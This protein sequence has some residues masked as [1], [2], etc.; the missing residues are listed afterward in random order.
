MDR[1][2]TR[3][4]TADD[5]VAL[6]RRIKDLRLGRGLTIKELAK[7][8]ELSAGAI[9]QIERGI[10]STSIRSIR[11]ICK[12]LQVPLGILFGAENRDGENEYLCR[13]HQR[14]TLDFGHGTIKQKLTAKGVSNLELLAVNIEP[15]GSSGPDTYSHDGEEMGLVL[16]GVLD[17]YIAEQRYHL[18]EGDAFAF[19]STMP[20]RFSNSGNAACRVLWVN[21]PA[22]YGN[23]RWPGRED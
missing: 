16:A 8:A 23:H 14:E 4:V 18:K 9:S 17:L 15:G 11:N 2:S 12:A 5:D 21:S 6:G 13:F 3:A 7:R 22:L 20:H 10:G 19:P 1:L